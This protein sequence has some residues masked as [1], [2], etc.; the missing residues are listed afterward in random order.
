L[1]ERLFIVG[2]RTGRRFDF[3]GV[4]TTGPGR[5]RDFLS[6]TVD[7]GWLR[8]DEYTL[9]RRPRVNRSGLA[10]AGYL[11]GRKKRPGGDPAVQQTH[12]GYRQV[13][14]AEGLGQTITTKT[15]TRYL[16]LI[17]GRVRR[18]VPDEVRSL[19]GFPP[20]FRLGPLV[21]EA[22]RQLGNSVFVPCVAAIM[23]AIASQLF[24]VRAETLAGYGSTMAPSPLHG[25]QE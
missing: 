25:D 8:P 16:V 14:D 1:R 19:M 9:L 24:G 20:W 15:N 7:C 22:H 17:D 23:R 13:Y 11:T 4:V 18:I 6:P 21:Q 5:I 10:F 3:G 12:D 2:S